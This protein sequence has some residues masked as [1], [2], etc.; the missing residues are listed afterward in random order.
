MM[1]DL[2]DEDMRDDGA[3]ALFVLGPEVENG[4]AIE[5]DHIR[6]LTRHGRGAALRET[7]SL[8]ET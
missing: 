8:E 3:Q 7:T 1:A 2:M 5:P 4:P 6:H